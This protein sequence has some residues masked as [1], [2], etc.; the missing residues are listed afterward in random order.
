LY[1]TVGGSFPK[2]AEKHIPVPW[3]SEYHLTFGTYQIGTKKDLPRKFWFTVFDYGI[4]FEKFLTTPD[5]VSDLSLVTNCP[6]AQETWRCMFLHL[7]VALRHHP[8]DLM[9][10]FR[11]HA[12]DLQETF[13]DDDESE[14]NMVMA[15]FGPSIN[16][17]TN[18]NVQ[19][20]LNSLLAL[21]PDEFNHVRILL[22]SFDANENASRLNPFKSIACYTPQ[23]GPHDSDGNWTGEDVILRLIGEHFTILIPDR[24][25]TAKELAKEALSDPTQVPEWSQRPIDSIRESIHAW[26]KRNP[27]DPINLDEYSCPYNL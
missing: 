22:V 8:Y 13:P 24:E 14:E 19:V 15:L 3:H 20:D 21:W 9:L 12:R 6:S 7:G 25:Q 2:I 17:I 5:F 27:N 11:Q 1:R 4:R 18:P 16:T 10:K 23:H 26:N